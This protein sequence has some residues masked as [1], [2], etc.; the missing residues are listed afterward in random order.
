MKFQPN[1]ASDPGRLQR[2]AEIQRTIS[3]EITWDPRGG[4]VVS[5]DCP[6]R[7]P[8]PR[9]ATVTVCRSP[10]MPPA[11]L[12][13]RLHRL[14]QLCIHGGTRTFRNRRPGHGCARPAPSRSAVPV[15][16]GMH[17]TAHARHRTHTHLVQ[18][19]LPPATRHPPSA[20][21]RCP[22]GSCRAAA[23]LFGLVCANE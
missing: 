19:S 15:T 23:A 12:L 10:F 21:G 20:P 16:T 11:F 9:W 7:N 18:S 4:S 6:L 22:A 3:N 5:G 2:P 1:T 14:R 13:L 17:G 8:K